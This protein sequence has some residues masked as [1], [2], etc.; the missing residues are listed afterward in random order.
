M[1]ALQFQHATANGSGL[2]E[3]RNCMDYSC[4]KAGRH[5]AWIMGVQVGVLCTAHKSAWIKSWEGALD[6]DEAEVA[7]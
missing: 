5:Q 7:A 1:S 3:A 4:N 2:Y 6:R